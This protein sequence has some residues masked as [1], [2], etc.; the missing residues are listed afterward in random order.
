MYS[1]RLASSAICL[2]I[3]LTPAVQALK[4]LP[5]LNSSSGVIIP[6]K[7]T[8]TDFGTVLDAEVSVGGQS[9]L[10]YLDS[11][12]SDTWV[13]KTGF[14]CLNISDNAILSQDVCNYGTT[15]N[16]SPTFQQISNQTF[17]VKYGAGISTGI[18]GYEK[19]TLGGL[20]VDK[21]EIGVADRITDPGDGIDSGTLGLGYPALTSAHPGTN[22]PNESISYFQNRVI[23]DPLLYNIYK[24]GLVK[25]YFSLAIDRTP[26]N[27]SKGNG[28]SLALGCL[29][30]VPH[31][32]DFAIAPVEILSVI[33]DFFTNDKPQKS[34][35]ALSIKSAS[36]G[37]SFKPLNKNTTSF[38]SI[39]DCGNFF[40]YLP[41]SLA[42]SL[43]SLFQPP[44][45]PN[46]NFEV[47][48][49]FDVPCAATPPSFGLTFNNNVTVY[50]D[51]RDMIIQNADGT[52]GSAIADS[53]QIGSQGIAFAILG[54]P[55]LK[56]MVAVFDTGRDE[57][58]FAERW[59][60]TSTGVEPSS[61]VVA[62]KA[63][64]SVPVS[65]TSRYS[66]SF[67]A[68]GVLVILSF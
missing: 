5:R 30:P 37:A 65:L 68:W 50:M 23:Y 54:T 14:Q 59:N 4:L 6:L 34:Y 45:T 56:S 28:G 26:V 49:Q 43:N 20:T 29:P 7:A 31:N 46:L 22:Y 33:P 57:I 61:T 24:Q 53:D 40:N 63:S 62:S 18:V 41:S 66:W 17:G 55:W 8:Y 9:F 47:N 39:V 58:R 38:Q 67:F 11:G 21:Q 27:V 15:Y 51:P 52:C 35:W 12:S 25:P 13:A 10:L 64:N 36:Y 60:T 16:I 32:P 48:G 44:A 1:L 42:A 2:T 3:W 19:V